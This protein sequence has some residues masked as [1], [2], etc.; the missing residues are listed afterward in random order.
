M[1]NV[2]V[3]AQTFTGGRGWDRCLGGNAMA[4]I[5]IRKEFL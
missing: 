1:N 3:K 5:F 4:D 2:K